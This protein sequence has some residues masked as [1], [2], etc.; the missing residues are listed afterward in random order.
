[1]IFGACLFNFQNCRWS[2]NQNTITVYV[3]KDI[4]LKS[5]LFLIS[6]IGGAIA[7]I[8]T[9]LLFYRYDVSFLILALMLSYLSIGDLVGRK[10]F[11]E[12]S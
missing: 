2:A 7:S 6:I 5:T 11:K 4:K 12:Y 9:F 1:M 8:V 10:L 3:A